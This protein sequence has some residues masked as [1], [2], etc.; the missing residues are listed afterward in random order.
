[1][2]SNHHSVKSARRGA[3]ETI[4]D[5][6]AAAETRSV[7]GEEERMKRKQMVLMGLI[8]GSARDDARVRSK[9]LD[10]LI[11]QATGLE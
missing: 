1:M 5:I 7:I 8:P 6:A 9:R 11:R 3:G 4:A 2:S 10:N